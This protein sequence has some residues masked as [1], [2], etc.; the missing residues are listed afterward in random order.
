MSFAMWTECS[1]SCY[2]ICHVDRVLFVV[3]I[4][5]CVSCGVLCCVNRAICELLCYLSCGLTDV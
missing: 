2:V 5:C 1:V 4:E 3:W